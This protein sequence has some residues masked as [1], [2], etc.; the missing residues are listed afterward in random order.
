MSQAKNEQVFKSFRLQSAGKHGVGINTNLRQSAVLRFNSTQT[1]FV[2]AVT[3][4]PLVKDATFAADKTHG[5]WNE[6]K[7]VYCGGASL[8]NDFSFLR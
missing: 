7:R 3:V 6:C 4:V 5:L 8:P 1:W 2:H